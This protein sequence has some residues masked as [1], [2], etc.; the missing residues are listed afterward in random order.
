MARWCD[1]ES[2]VVSVGL[3]CRIMG[4]LE[5]RWADQPIPI[6]APRQRA[7]L[8]ALLLYPDRV[9]SAERI[10]TLVW[11]NDPPP[12]ALKTLQTLVHRVRR[13]LEAVAPGPHLIT[14]QPGYLL[15]LPPEAVDSTR[16]EQLHQAGGQA[17]RDGNADAAARLLRQAEKLSRGPA[18][19]D[20]P[21]DGLLG[22]EAD[23]LR[24]LQLQVLEDRIEA[25]LRTGRHADLVAELRTLVAAHPLRERLC[26]QLMV[27]L[28]RSGR[29]A[30]A[31][32]VYQAQQQVL[33]DQLGVSPTL[34]LQDLHRAILTADPRLASTGR[35]TEAERAHVVTSA[36]SP[37]TEP[38]VA[39]AAPAPTRL[40]LDAPDFTGRRDHIAAL[41]AAL[42]ADGPSAAVVLITG[43]A[44]VGKTSL[45]VH[46]GH[47][48]G[49][50]FPDGR[51][52]IDLGETKRT[53]SADEALARALRMLGVPRDDVAR[54]PT[55]RAEQ[56][57]ALITRRRVLVVLDNAIDEAQV[58]PLLPWGGGSA[59]VVT[60]R[61]PL[62]GLTFAYRLVLPELS[63]DE[64]VELLGRMAG[65]GRVAAEPGHA[66]RIVEL[67]GRLPLAIRIAGAKLAVKR[68]WALSDLM[69]RLVDEQGRLDELQAGDLAVR[70]SLRVSYEA[71]DESD[72]D[73]FRM[74]GQLGGASFPA[75]VPAT[76]ADM[77]VSDMVDVLERLVDWQLLD[78]TERDHA[79][80]QRY[81]LHDLVAL[82]A[83]EL[84]RDVGSAD[85][86]HV[87]KGR[88][89]SIWL[90]IFDAM[91]ARLVGAD[92]LSGFD[93]PVVVGGPERASY[94]L[95]WLPAFR[96]T[97]SVSSTDPTALVRES[98]WSVAGVLVSMSFELWSQWD[99]W[100]LT[101][102]TALS[103]GRR[104]DD[105][106]VVWPAT[107][108]VVPDSLVLK[109][110]LDRRWAPAVAGVEE[111]LRTFRRL[112]EVGWH[113]MALLSLG[114]LHRG[115]A[116]FDLANATLS[117][118]VDLFQEL[119]VREWEAAALFSLGS[120]RVVEGD[121]RGTV[122]AYRGCL[123]IFN[124]LD[125]PLWLAY[126]YRALGYAYQQHGRFAEAKEAICHALP[127][128]RRYDDQLLWRAHATLTL[129][130][131]ELGLGCS[132]AARAHFD[133]CLAMFRAYGDPRSEALA[134][135]SR[136]RASTGS[137][138]ETFLRAALAAFVRLEDPVGVTV[139]LRDL[140]V[141]CG[142]DSLPLVRSLV[143]ELGLKTLLN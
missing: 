137:D 42:G 86:R 36:L 25:D 118:C 34:E 41:A 46:V 74:L 132:L 120:L 30:A 108:D 2:M 91:E 22:A 124:D 85:E 5:I 116:R 6:A 143:D 134:L 87:A 88:I 122:D 15:R 18:L 11:G 21:T 92:R 99:D 102:Q 121:L 56:Y 100:R 16:F 77:A 89:V 135:R 1:P 130:L 94:P 28:Y 3:E 12:T 70:A 68:H 49:E 10:I 136:A 45:A 113:A 93:R 58:R 71:L 76:L 111:S 117:D 110:G 65:A 35:M 126:T 101:R 73:V 142:V 60:S 82:Y 51:L 138:V 29:Q 80:R 43:K 81:R 4:P 7:V 105:R 20:V 31:L 72:R 50:R 66:A 112:G 33:A 109:P 95:G 119:G 67:C 55:E 106:L 32:R 44:G 131:A 96:S 17:L 47:R 133:D 61:L 79:G 140:G 115:N 97:L 53:V 83:R 84:L 57:Q 8:A 37:S 59:A 48:H 63:A 98:G 69:A 104:A 123:A 139:T 23:R 27:A 107:D 39:D 9:L 128:L 125:D 24:E 75:W 40:P 129:G 14:R 52:F 13:R 103:T 54:D 38:A 78:V 62:A 26:G 141:M 114:N 127:V 90:A 19:A 64:S